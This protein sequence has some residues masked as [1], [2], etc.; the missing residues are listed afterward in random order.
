MARDIVADIADAKGIITGDDLSAYFSEWQQPLRSRYKEY[1]LFGARPPYS[2]GA[3]VFFAMNLLEKF[4]LS[5]GRT[6]EFYRLLAEVSKMAFAHR[7]EL[8]DPAFWN[9][10]VNVVRD[11]VS[12]SYADTMSKRIPSNGTYTDPKAYMWLGGGK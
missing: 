3:C 10:T 5:A 1:D 6:L 9:N 4:D 2:G 11:M 12:K 8:G 7:M